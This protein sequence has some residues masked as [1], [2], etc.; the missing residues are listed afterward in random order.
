MDATL[1]FEGAFDQQLIANEDFA[2][3]LGQKAGINCHQS[4]F[5]GDPIRIW[6]SQ[7]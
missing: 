1:G 6:Q 5:R 7:M 3:G 4:A 2:A